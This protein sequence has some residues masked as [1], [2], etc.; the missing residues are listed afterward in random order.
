MTVNSTRMR[1]ACFR[2][3]NAISS[4]SYQAMERVPVLRSLDLSYNQLTELLPGTFPRI[5]T[6]HT[7]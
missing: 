2:H 5:P 7:L 3:H 1:V 6:L 4:L